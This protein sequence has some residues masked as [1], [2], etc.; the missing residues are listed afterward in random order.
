MSARISRLVVS[1]LAVNVFAVLFAGLPN[2]APAQF[3]VP[4]RGD[5]PP[6]RRPP[7]R[8]I[9]PVPRPVFSSY[10][11]RVVDVQA[12]VHDQ[13]AKIRM[14]Q[15]FQNTSSTDV[16]AQVVFP[17]PEGAAISDLTLL[18]DGK[19]LP[20]RLLPKEEARRI[21]EEI[22]RRQRDPALLE[23]L[24]GG[25]FQTS[26][27]PIP[28][29]ADRTVE[30]RY[31]QLLRKS[32]GLVDLLLPLGTLKHANHAI[33]TL[34]VSLK[35]DTTE[36]LKSVYSPTHTVTIDRP[37]EHHAIGKVT[38]TN[39]ASPDDL[40]VL[41]STQSGAV[42]H[43]PDQLSAERKRG[44]LFPA[45][46]QPRSECRSASVAI[47]E[48]SRDRRRPLRQ[49]GRPEDRAGAAGR[50]VFPQPT[51]SRATCSTSSPTTPTSKPFARSC[52]A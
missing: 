20:G 12:T 40:R 48:D 26:V 41:Y 39:I 2:L 10:R 23:Y 35:L 24:G 11:I 43:E 5:A 3:L 31:T 49:H 50:Q 16:E 8:P 42:G 37:D 30:I 51:R 1:V 44:R 38:L 6:V 28:P 18:Y 25:M 29:R 7:N 34:S 9:R 52:S 19:E 17:I 21:Y 27:F 14:S 15:V 32:G 36:P 13:A 33:D 4:D 46:G 22:V 47:P 45:A